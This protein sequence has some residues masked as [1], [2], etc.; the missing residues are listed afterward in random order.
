MAQRPSRSAP[1]AQG[2]ERL[3]P[4]QKAAGSN[5]AGG[6]VASGSETRAIQCLRRLLQRPSETVYLSPTYPARVCTSRIRLLVPAWWSRELHTLSLRLLFSQLWSSPPQPR[7]IEVRILA[8][9]IQFNENAN[10]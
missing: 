5:P 1:V 7:P 6:T 10:P 9:S 8:D 2:I 3:P 4:E